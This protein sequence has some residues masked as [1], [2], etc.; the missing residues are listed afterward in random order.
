MG[1]FLLCLP[2]CWRP[3]AHGSHVM[4]ALVLA[5]VCVMVSGKLFWELEVRYCEAGTG[6]PLAW[7]HVL[8]HVLSGLACYFGILG[9]AH[10]RF[11][12]F[13]VGVAAAAPSEPWPLM[14]I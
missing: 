13:G 9:D 11:S 6:G 1:D 10:N 5:Y 8:W 14:W 7:L 12:A 3:D 2:C 4:K